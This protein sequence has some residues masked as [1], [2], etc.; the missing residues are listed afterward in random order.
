M[1]IHKGENSQH[2]QRP[3]RVLF[4]AGEFGYCLSNFSAFTVH[5]NGRTWQTSEH[6]YQA[7]GFNDEA[8]VEQIA[9]APSAHVALKL[10][11]ENAHALRPAWEHEK[12]EVMKE[13][14]RAKLNQHEYVRGT[15]IK[16]G[17]AELIEDSPKDAFWGRGA[18]WNGRNHL[19]HIWMELRAEIVED[20][21]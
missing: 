13:I 5:W 12:R 18:D 6:A 2:E 3:T 15:L 19:G 16:S 4:Y 9:N 20:T 11:L 8:I 21:Q 10:A 14:C 17:D 7:A 1:F